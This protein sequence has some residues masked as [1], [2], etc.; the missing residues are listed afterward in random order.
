M[1]FFTFFQKLIK[2]RIEEAKQISDV[3]STWETLAQPYE[4]EI[5]KE[6]VFNI[7]G[8]LK[9]AIPSLLEKSNRI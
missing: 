9:K 8:P 3:L 5:S 4:P 6:W 1:K 7:F 2:L